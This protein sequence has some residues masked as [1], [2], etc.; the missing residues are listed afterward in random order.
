MTPPDQQA[1][2]PNGW[3]ASHGIVDVRRGVDGDFVEVV[4]GC[5]EGLR[6]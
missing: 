2:R 5:Q 3:K 1:A 6:F 4:I